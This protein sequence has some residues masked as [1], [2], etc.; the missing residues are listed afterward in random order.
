MPKP[1]TIFYIAAIGTA[2]G[3]ISVYFFWWL[4]SRY[5]VM[6]AR[7]RP[8]RAHRRVIWRDPGE[9]EQ[10]DFRDGPGGSSGA[11]A[12]PFRFIEEHATGSNPCLS[13]R[14][15]RGRTW[16]VKWGDEVKSETFA[17]RLVWAAGYFVET[18]YFV[19]EGVIE[20]ATELGR[21]RECIDEECRFREARFEHD[22]AG[23][24][25]HFDEHGWSWDDNPFVGT[26]QLNGLKILLML[27]SNWDNK[28]VRDVARGSNT[29]I[30]E[31]RLADGTLEARYLIIDWG[32]T[33]GRW[34]VPGTRAKWD[35][36][37]FESQ[38]QDFIRGVEGGVIRWGYI[39]QRTDEATEGIRVE[40]ARWLYRYI[41]RVTDAQLREGMLAS[42]ATDEEAACFVRAIRAR[43][44]QLRRVSELGDEY[45]PADI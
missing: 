20:G 27:L 24:R 42:G 41:G 39:G 32:A 1:T 35:C 38:N 4:V 36:A 21:A 10:L 7:P 2:V 33:L 11:P 34:G 19:P 25:K 18:A 14:D 16:R 15:G 22:E 43:L 26:K 37:A 30:F 8:V 44:E 40:D 28:D 23:V 29:A 5:R 3:V 13:V 6:A 45:R 9:V 12:P 17:V 31:H